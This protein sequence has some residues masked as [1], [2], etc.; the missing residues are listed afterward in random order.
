MQETLVLQDILVLLANL[1]FAG[2]ILKQE[3]M[4][5]DTRTKISSIVFI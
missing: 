3:D 2:L 4:K 1:E 5:S